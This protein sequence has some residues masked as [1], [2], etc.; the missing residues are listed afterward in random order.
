M[1]LGTSPAVGPPYPQQGSE[2][3]AVPGGGFPAPKGGISRLRPLWGITMGVLCV[4]LAGQEEKRSGRVRIQQPSPR[5][6]A[7]AAAGPGGPHGCCLGCTVTNK[8]N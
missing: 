8:G 6:N 5:V 7:A 2:Q 4:G 3:A 1:D